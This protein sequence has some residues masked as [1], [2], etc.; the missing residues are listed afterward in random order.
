MPVLDQLLA[1]IRSAAIEVIDLTARLESTTPVIQLPP[2]FANTVPFSAARGQ[3]VRRTRTR[4]VLE[5]HQH[6]RAHRYPLRRASA[7]D[8]RPRRRG[9]LRGPGDA[10]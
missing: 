9:H 10:A 8:Q 4:L 6:R 7:L 5:R 1:A 3:P 2:P